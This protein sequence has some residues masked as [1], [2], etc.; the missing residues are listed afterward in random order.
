MRKILLTG[1]NGQVG[2]ELQRTLAPLGEVVAVDQQEMDL[3]DPVSVR[4][5]IREIRPGLIVNAAAYTAVD[6][7]E[8]E[9]DLA[10]AINGVAP[11]IMAEEAKRLNAAIVHYSTDY[12]FNGSKKSQYSEDDIPNPLNVYGKTKL[13]GEQAIQAVGVP[14][15]ILRT[16]WVYGAHGKNFL[17]TILRLAR[18]RSEL[19]IV[20]DQIGAP[21]WSRMLA[22]VTAQMLS[23]FYPPASGAS[24]SVAD[25]SGLYHVVS[26]GLTSWY[27]FA[28]K[29]LE[30]ESSRTARVVPKLIPIPTIDFPLPARRPLNSG[31]SIEKLKHV[32]GLVLPAWEESLLLCMDEITT[33]TAG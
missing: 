7:A 23:Q 8:S 17:L 30:I 28:R 15:L 27:G 11:G 20:D 16:S 6:K 5:I 22:E 29:I 9:P 24:V 18:E 14:H 4:K 33:L 12:V 10:M 13:A 21:T 1:K 31:M 25:I 19:K 2:W 3:V 32:C 26:S